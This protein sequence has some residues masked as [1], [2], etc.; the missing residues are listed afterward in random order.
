MKFEIH[1]GN[2]RLI[3]PTGLGIAG[4]ILKKTDLKRRL[5]EVKLRNNANPLIK[6][7]DV[8]ISYIGL[9][10]QGKS[11][12]DDVR[13][14]LEDKE[15]YSNALDIRNIPSSET[16][17]QRMDMVEKKFRSIILEENVKML[18]A[19][20]AQLTP[21]YKNW[22]PLDID[23]SPFDNSNTKKEG[24]SYTY[25][26]FDGYAPIFAY[27]GEEGYQIN[28]EFRAGSTHCQ[29]NTD[30]FLKETLLLARKLT[31]KPI[32]VRM[33]SGYDS[34]DNLKVCH[35]EETSC[36]YIIKRNIRR[37][38]ISSWQAIAEENKNSKI[39]EPREG[40]KIY[41]GSVYWNIENSDRK[42]RV[43][44]QVIERTSRADG[45]I[46]LTPETEVQTFWTSLDLDEQE[47]I[48]LYKAH[49]TSEQFRLFAISS[50]FAK[51]Q[52]KGV[53]SL[54]DKSYK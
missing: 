29:K 34:V 8:A 44:Y 43:V 15:F 24:V 28:M 25:K 40:K 51:K 16:L 14:M 9:L 30:N 49:G 18:K 4:L 22:L 38:R 46:M 21:C 7:G 20:D 11:D 17:R 19:T 2:E 27:L 50:G 39:S 3:T 53:N 36:D 10:C 23:V 32:L 41:T 37:E 35:A 52:A 6:N 42:V 5:N 45:Q 33:D 47:I 26:K 13:E 12:F 48:G 54:Q 31:T 1:F